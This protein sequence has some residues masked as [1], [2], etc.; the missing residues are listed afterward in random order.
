[1]SDFA[2]IANLHKAH[3]AAVEI[4]P[5]LNRAVVAS[6]VMDEGKVIVLEGLLDAFIS[7]IREVI[8]SS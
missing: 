8:K 5:M 4:M 2:Y 3:N 6:S 1:M 7:E